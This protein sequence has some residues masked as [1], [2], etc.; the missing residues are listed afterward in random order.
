MRIRYRSDGDT[1]N[2]A[3]VSGVYFDPETM[4]FT[5]YI[6]DG[7]GSDTDYARIKFAD[8]QQQSVDVIVVDDIIKQ[9]LI[10]GYYDFTSEE[11]YDEVEWPDYNGVFSDGGN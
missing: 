9:F 2:I 1:F 3:T 11:L 4:F 8:S 5:F 10:N 6:T 7:N